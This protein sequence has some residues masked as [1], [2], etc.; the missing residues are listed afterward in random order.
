MSKY[1]IF[2]AL[3]F[4]I[5][6]SAQDQRPKIGVTL[7]GG[8]ARGIAHIG[9]LKV[10]EEVGIQ[11]D[12]VTGVSMGAIVGGLYS[13]GYSA[14]SIAQIFKSIDWDLILT[15]KISERKLGF[16]EKALVRNSL[17]NFSLTS[18]GLTLTDGLISGHQISSLMTYHSW[19]ANEITDFD[20]LPI[21]FRA[22]A[23]DIT[24]CKQVTFDSGNIQ[25][26][27]QASMAVP[28]VFTP[29]E[30]DTFLLVDGGLIR[31]FAVPEIK[32]LGADFI[33]GSYTGRRLYTRKELN[34]IG[35]ILGQ[36]GSFVGL[37][38]SEEQKKY[39]DILITPEFEKI[40]PTDF[41][42]VDSIINVGYYAAL[43]YKK[44]LEQLADS[45]NLR[46]GKKD[47]SFLLNKNKPLEIDDIRIEGNQFISDDQI[48]KMLELSVGGMIDR[49]GMKE[50]MD[51]LYASNL[52]LKI[53]YDIDA[54]N[55]SNTLV[56][57]CKEKSRSNINAF[58]HYDTYD[59]L[60]VYSSLVTR[61]FL[62]DRSR[63]TVEAYLGNY[64]RFRAEYLFFIGKTNRWN[65]KFGLYHSKDFL[66]AVKF[67]N[68]FQGFNNFTSKVY[69]D[70]NY[71]LGL[72]NNFTIGMEYENLVLS[73][74]ILNNSPL[75][76]TGFN[77]L[78]YY[79]TYQLN[80]LDDYYYPRSGGEVFI[81]FKNI[82]FQNY[83]FSLNKNSPG[84]SDPERYWTF[85][86]KR[87]NR[88]ILRS[89]YF[90]PI[91]EK[92]SI[93]IKANGVITFS[94]RLASNDFVLIGG[95]EISNDRSLPFYGFKAREFLSKNA[96]GGGFG[97]YYRLTDKWQFGFLADTYF[98]DDVGVDSD[99][100]VLDPFVGSGLEA[101]FNS[102]VG[103][104]RV[105]LMRGEYF[106][107]DDR[108]FTNFKLYVSL[109]F[110]F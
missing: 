41:R 73:P 16:E 56:I 26:V 32:D 44:Q 23:T 55:K 109:G 34:T 107:I 90:F 11:P 81:Q 94:N 14:D 5:T 74:L 48:L 37:S 22:V 62:L 77:N 91:K 66:P 68:T 6:L 79:A 39:V 103:P 76:R 36:I 99:S 33:I 42:K 63:L 95:P 82:G 69:L 57:K 27:M 93:A 18:D 19:P 78:N 9:L 35:T 3:F 106:N 71:R 80:L 52:F 86:Q 30:I 12:Y 58:L 21:P 31:N 89:R 40:S 64:Y 43:P 2:I 92:L 102:F 98:I 60:G 1:L 108:V 7:S 75:K 8:G 84:I 105:T 4:S 61:N 85:P 53:S 88:L 10:L 67:E 13:M 17:L 20:E 25:E 46:T 110:R 104:I 97:I 51:V 72:N 29:N 101:L 96:L 38:D 45:L 15:D 59:G 28:T 87:Y 49:D 47:I 50:K 83:S 100:R 24:W 70:F 65:T 54:S